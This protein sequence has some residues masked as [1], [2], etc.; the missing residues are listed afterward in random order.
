MKLDMPPAVRKVRRPP[1]DEWGRGRGHHPQCGAEWH[2]YRIEHC[3]LCHQTFSGTSIGDAHRVG[4]YESPEQRRCL[5]ADE[6]AA[7]GLW[8]E[9]NPYGTDV[10]H[11]TPNKNGIQKHHPRRERRDGA[12]S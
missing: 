8:V 12:E 1:D 11:G 6:M 4:P 3:T 9:T 10:W 7:L 5:T 2:G